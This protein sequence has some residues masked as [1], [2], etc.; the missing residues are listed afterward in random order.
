M[1]KNTT[2]QKATAAK[3]TPSISNSRYI[4]KSFE[5]KRNA[6]RTFTELFTDFLSQRFGGMTFLVGNVLWFSAW[7]L[8]NTG[9][10]PPFLPHVPIFDPFPFTL[11]TMAVSLEA[12]ILAIIVLISQNRASV[13]DDLREELDLQVNVIAEQELTKVLELLVRIAKKNGVDLSADQTLK[14]MLKTTNV[15]KIEMALEK[16]AQT[17][18]NIPLPWPPRKA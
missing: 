8:I 7:I 11:L 10:I 2:K 5:A 13:I 18:S 12:I 9:H 4:I 17:S 15:N 16:Q 3:T 6:Q 14:I 1:P